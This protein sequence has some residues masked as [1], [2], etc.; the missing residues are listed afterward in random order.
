MRRAQY[1]ADQREVSFVLSLP[2]SVWRISLPH[3]LTEFRYPLSNACGQYG[4]SY[5]D[6]VCTAGEDAGKECPLNINQSMK[7][8]TRSAGKR[9]VNMRRDSLSYFRE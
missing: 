7:A 4:A 6:I 9:R 8:V 3:Y 2:F 5:Q 1:A